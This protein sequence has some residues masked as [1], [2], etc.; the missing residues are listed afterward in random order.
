MGTFNAFG[1]TRQNKTYPKDSL[2]WLRP[3]SEPEDAATFG[4]MVEML[5]EPTKS[6]ALK[7]IKDFDNKKLTMEQVMGAIGF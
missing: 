3:K 7:A 5:S 6:K 1:P 2:Y 4:E